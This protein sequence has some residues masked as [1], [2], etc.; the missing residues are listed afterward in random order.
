MLVVVSSSVVASAQE[1]AADVEARTHFEAARLHFERGAYEEAQRE[2][3]AAYDLSH[4]AELL[5]NLFLTAERL[6]DYDMAIGYLEHYL[7]EGSPD[8]ERRATLEP[9]LENLRAR[10]DRRATPTEE[11]TEPVP[12]TT[13]ASG[14]DIV[15]AAIAFGVAG[16][17][18]VSFAIVGGLALAEDGSLESTCGTSC[19]DAQVST[20][21]TLG[22]V[23]DVS[24]IT[25]AVATTAGVVLLLTVGMPSGSSSGQTALVVPWLAPSGGGG[26]LAE[27]SF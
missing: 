2:F 15:P 13:T 7:A 23:A 3:Q 14:G 18:L 12:A 22:I 16:A 1:T 20:L 9:R 5:Y 21:G 11:P 27:G 17:A 8:A 4:R 26:L 6:A 19:T 24:W 10:R 25:A